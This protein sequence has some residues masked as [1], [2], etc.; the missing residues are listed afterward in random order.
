MS[1]T[2]PAAFRP[3]LRELPLAAAEL[4][5]FDAIVDVRSPGEYAIDH[6]PGALNY[7]VLSDD[8]R[9]RVGTL[10]TQQSAFEAKK[11]GAAIVARNVARH[12][13]EAFSAHPKSWKP[14]I[15]C[16]RGGSRSGAMTHI[17][18]SVGWNAR[19]LV[20]GYKAW[21]S[22]VIADLA[23]LPERYRYRVIC[24]R[25]GSG[26]SRL[27]EALAREGAQVLDLEQL[28]AHKG[29][30]LG[31][32]PGEPQPAQKL[33]ESRIWSA[34]SGFDPTLPVYV[35]AESKKVG[36]L[37]VPQSLIER[38]WEGECY[39]VRTPEAGRVVVLR[40]EYEHFLHNP[41]GLLEKLGCLAPLH[42]HSRVEEWKK[43]VESAE[44]DK[45][46]AN[47]LENHYDPA[48]ERS[49]FSNYRQAR[50]AQPLPV[51]DV[52][53]EGFRAIAKSLSG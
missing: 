36:N 30:I 22:Q 2:P 14:L 18:R 16:W 24:G 42:S 21:R 26:K 20:G 23:D 31:E 29:S 25:T 43:L 12:I 51:T 17:L 34:L 48:Y 27:L 47:M 4:A 53:P 44:W 45:F 15:Y 10:Y 13:D 8:E 5:F 11:V 33:F 7:P 40:Q 9:A 1:A 41:Q 39:E 50:T 37:R 38:M 46:V 6:L 52:S 32:L 3:D 19:Q 28:A 35:E 49:M